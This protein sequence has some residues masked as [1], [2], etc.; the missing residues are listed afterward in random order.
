M[1]KSLVVKLAG[2]TAAAVAIVGLSGC[3]MV[4]DTVRARVEDVRSIVQQEVSAAAQEIRYAHAD[5]AE[6]LRDSIHGTKYEVTA[7]EARDIEKTL[8]GL[9]EG[10]ASSAVSGIMEETAA[11]ASYFGSGVETWH[12]RGLAAGIAS[13]VTAAAEEAID[14]YAKYSYEDSLKIYEPYGLELD[15]ATQEWYF[16]A[17]PIAGINDPGSMTVTN[18][19]L[20]GVGAYILVE[21]DAN[22]NIT[23]LKEVSIEEFAKAAGLADNTTIEQDVAK[24]GAKLYKENITVKGMSEEQLYKTER[25]LMVKYRGQNVLVQCN[26]YA[27]SFDADERLRLSSFC[28]SDKNPIGV[29]VSAGLD[30]ADEMDLDR[31]DIKKV[32]ELLLDMLKNNAYNDIESVEAAAK[33]L[34][35][36]HYGISET[37]LIAKAAV[38][39]G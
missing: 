25:S 18:G 7:E 4:V 22:G 11:E 28:S 35:A 39:E 36:Q 33:N 6:E 19:Y 32:D 21:R 23:G 34:V 29:G 3:S 17:K 20:K 37:N 10:A 24:N 16:G 15:G 31:L 13:T 27:F 8:D 26:D 9:T 1:K 5:V 38:I 30:I 14:K 12:E 2:V